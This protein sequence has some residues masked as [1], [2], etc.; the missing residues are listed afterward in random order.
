MPVRRTFT[1]YI[2]PIVDIYLP[3]MHTAKFDLITES[4]RFKILATSESKRLKF[5]SLYF[6]PAG[7]WL[8]IL[9]R[10]LKLMS[11]GH[12]IVTGMLLV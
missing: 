6:W 11:V 2:L 10:I 12:R 4:K 9:S 5:D 8:S 3:A 1:P 7:Q